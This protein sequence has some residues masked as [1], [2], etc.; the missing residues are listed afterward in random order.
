ME[1][2]R[3]IDGGSNKPQWDNL[4]VVNSHDQRM[5]NYRKSNRR[6]NPSR[7]SKDLKVQIGGQMIHEPELG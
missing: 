1:S 6:T 2:N 5:S 7:H 4:D 3:E